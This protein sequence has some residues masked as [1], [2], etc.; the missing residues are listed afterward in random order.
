MAYLAPILKRMTY[1]SFHKGYTLKGLL[2]DLDG[3]LYVDGMALQGAAVALQQLRDL[4]LQCRFI[5]NTTTQQ[6]Q[7]IYQQLLRLGF[8]VSEDEVLSVLSVC[9][10]YLSEQGG[11]VRLLMREEVCHYFSAITQDNENP[12]YIVIGDIGEDWSY[13]LL[14]GVALQL[15]SGTQLLALHKN[16][17]WKAHQGLKLDVGLFVGGLEY[18]SGQKAKV[19][20]KPS[21]I[22]FEQAIQSMGLCAKEVLMLGDDMYSDISGAQQQGIYAVQ[23]KTGKFRQQQYA[24]SGIHADALIASIVDLPELLR[25]FL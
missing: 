5:T 6:P 22:F 12:D 3:V 14:N 13:A 23:V 19:L 2:L 9:K 21:A 15:L 25:G 24:V 4:G 8:N 16:R 18:V 7:V 1:S 10:D 17:W 11:S 20:G